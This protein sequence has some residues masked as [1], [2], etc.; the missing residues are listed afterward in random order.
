MASKPPATPLQVQIF[1]ALCRAFADPAS[2]KQCST[3]IQ[4]HKGSGIGGITLQAVQAHLQD[5]ALGQSVARYVAEQVTDDPEQHNHDGFTTQDVEN[6]A[7][8]GLSGLSPEAVTS[9][10]RVVTECYD[11]LLHAWVNT[12]YLETAAAAR[13]K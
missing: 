9:L 6:F 13:S 5:P 2:L 8:K 4:N 10:L 3:F 11:R 1:E 12:G 7:S